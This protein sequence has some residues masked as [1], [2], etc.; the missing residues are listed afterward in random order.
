ML[1][2][3]NPALTNVDLAEMR[4]LGIAVEPAS[5]SGVAAEMVPRTVLLP[6][7]RASAAERARAFP[8]GTIG[9]TGFARATIPATAFGSGAAVGNLEGLPVDR[10]ATGALTQIVR[11][12]GYFGADTLLLGTS[13]DNT[14][15]R[16]AGYVAIAE[17]SC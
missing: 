1:G 12:R 8:S 5:G 7:V 4:Y 16:S 13:A 3:I 11:D 2:S 9:S 17:I 6:T 15:L 14:V 10:I